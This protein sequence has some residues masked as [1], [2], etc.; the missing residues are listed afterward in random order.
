[1]MVSRCRFLNGRESICEC[2]VIAMA[3]TILINFLK[4]VLVTLVP[5]A[6][7]LV[8]LLTRVM[9]GRLRLIVADDEENSPPPWEFL[10]T[11]L[12]LPPMALRLFRLGGV[13]PARVG[14]GPHPGLCGGLPGRP[15]LA[16]AWPAP[17]P[18]GAEAP[19]ADGAARHHAPGRTWASRGL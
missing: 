7:C 1:M 19:W 14:H 6:R 16:R 10:A 12:Q 5:D 2:L 17:A 9:C 3:C 18:P 13:S 4:G 11:L 8:S 15:R